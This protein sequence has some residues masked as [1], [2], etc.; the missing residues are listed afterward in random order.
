[1]PQKAKDGHL[2]Y[3]VQTP[4]VF[5]EYELPAV[6][7][8]CFWDQSPEELSKMDELETLAQALGTH[9]LCS[10]YRRG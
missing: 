1:M 2:W 6:D 4:S 5:R 3:S 10:Q 9:V 7:T 8:T